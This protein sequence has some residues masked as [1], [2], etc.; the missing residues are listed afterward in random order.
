MN[1]KIQKNIRNKPKLLEILKSLFIICSY[2]IV[3]EYIFKSIFKH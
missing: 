3:H 2:N 1:Q